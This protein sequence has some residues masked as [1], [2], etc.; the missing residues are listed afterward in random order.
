MN[1]IFKKNYHYIE[2]YGLIDILKI[3]PI[4]DINFF[5]LLNHQIYLKNILS[6]YSPN[7]SILLFH[8][9]GVGKTCSAITIAETYNDIYIDDNSINKTIIL[10]SENIQVGWKKI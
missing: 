4:N 8:G 5:K 3:I 1:I 2:N 9:V 6:P 7:N 10:A